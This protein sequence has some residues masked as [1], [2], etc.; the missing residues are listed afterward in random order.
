MKD[1]YKLPDGRSIRVLNDNILVQLDNPDELSRGGIY[2]P[3][4]SYEHPYSTGRVMA[5][6]YH[7][8]VER[9]EE[10]KIV[11]QTKTPIAGL[12]VGDGIFCI[13]FL[14]QQDSNRTLQRDFGAGLIRIK[15]TDV[16]F[17]F[18]YETE[19]QRFQSGGIE[20]APTVGV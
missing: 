5:V 8:G 11:G 2:L 10:G 4:G 14:D 18:D 20:V 12:E 15:P 19:R 13:R 3:R 6:G 17:V 1:T 9:N 7:H 16:M